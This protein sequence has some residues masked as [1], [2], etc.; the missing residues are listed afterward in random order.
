M[1]FPDCSFQECGVCV[2]VVDQVLGMAHETTHKAKQ[3][4]KAE[5]KKV[6]DELIKAG[7]LT[8]KDEKKAKKETEAAEAEAAANKPMDAAAEQKLI[9]SNFDGYC[10]DFAKGL[11]KKE[12]AFLAPLKGTISQPV[13]QGTPVSALDLCRTM[14]GRDKDV[15]GKLLYPLKNPDDEKAPKMPEEPKPAVKKAVPKPLK[16]VV[17]PD[18]EKKKRRRL[19]KLR[20]M[21]AKERLRRMKKMTMSAKRRLKRRLK[22]K[23]LRA[24]K[25]KLG[26]RRKRKRRL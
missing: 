5:K 25:R 17:K 7:K 21:K 9:E 6:N 13:A 2:T 16:K 19:R 23:A 15:C 24:A 22:R 11:E 1:L 26:G 3:K 20:R 10:R 12:C 14:A 18:A 4:E 8:A